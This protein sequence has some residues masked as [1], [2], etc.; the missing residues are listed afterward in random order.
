MLLSGLSCGSCTGQQDGCTGHNDH[1]VQALDADCI[2]VIIVMKAHPIPGCTPISGRTSG[3][4]IEPSAVES[5]EDWPR[6]SGEEN[7]KE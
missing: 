4:S 3:G 1:C 5:I 7:G 2:T 6:V